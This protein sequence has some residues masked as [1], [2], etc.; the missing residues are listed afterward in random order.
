MK[1]ENE[2]VT[3]SF[4]ARGGG[5][6][7][8]IMTPEERT[9]GVITCSTGNHGQGVGK[10]AKELGC[11]LQVYVPNGANEFKVNKIKAFGAEIKYA[12]DDAGDTEVHAHKCADDEGKVYISPYNDEAVIAG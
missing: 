12:C 4:K 9:K 6:K 2:Q 7:L 8:L 1:M 3:G 5:N 11:A 10:M